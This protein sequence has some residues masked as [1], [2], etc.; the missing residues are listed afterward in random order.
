MR[1]VQTTMPAYPSGR[2]MQSPEFTQATSRLASVSHRESCCSSNG[3][4][5]TAAS[6][7]RRHGSIFKK[8]ANKEAISDLLPVTDKCPTMASM[9]YTYGWA[10]GKDLRVQTPLARGFNIGHCLFAL[11]TIRRI[12]CRTLIGTDDC[13]SRSSY[14]NCVACRRVNNRS[15]HCPTFRPHGT[16]TR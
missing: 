12:L 7:R 13:E 6:A 3:E 11:G 1:R 15:L 5:M 9:L 16:V 10:S 14:V 8:F 4:S 2:R